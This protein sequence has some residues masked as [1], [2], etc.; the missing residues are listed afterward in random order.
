MT[1]AE[2]SSAL[3]AAVR[4]AVAAGELAVP[5]PEGAPLSWAGGAYS[6]PLALRLAAGAGRPAHEVAGVIA[7]RLAMAPGVR[8]V[9][10]T[11]PGF[12]TITERAPGALAAAIVAA[13]ERYARAELPVA[14]ARWPDR[15]RTFGNPGFCVR[16]A[17]SR[18]AAIGRRARDLRIERAD[19]GPLN[20]PPE[21]RLLGL[22]AELP[23]RAG[24]AERERD[25]DPLKRQLE[26]IADVYHDVY[27][28]C[29]AL[30]VGDE[31][32]TRAH[33]ARLTLAEAVRISLDNGLH[34]L[35]ETPRELL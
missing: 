25:A 24:Q 3:V 15:P 27:E 10:V 23:S 32:P 22:L 31:E 26:R 1:G 35:G 2:L 13:G 7:E 34:T 12:L 33:G 18:A 8:R 6:S 28:R 9:D 4:D 17:Y 19:P 21:I 16:F 20:E 30:P 11:G 29:P 5:I 14:G